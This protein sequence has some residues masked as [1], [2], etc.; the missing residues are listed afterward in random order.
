MVYSKRPCRN[1]DEKQISSVHLGPEIASRISISSSGALRIEQ[2]KVVV[3]VV[4]AAERGK[5]AEVGAA[6]SVVFVEVVEVEQ[7]STA[8]SWPVQITGKLRLRDKDRIES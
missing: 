4:E 8:V 1:R 6:S 7:T 5:V 3:V 2:V